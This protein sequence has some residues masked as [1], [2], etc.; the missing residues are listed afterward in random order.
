MIIA[1]LLA[2]LANRPAAAI[3]EFYRLVSRGEKVEKLAGSFGFT[4]GPVWIPEKGEL[5][6]SDIPNDRIVR[7]APLRTGPELATFRLP[8]GNSNGLVLD[9][10]GRLIACEHGNRRVSRTG[11]DG[12]VA[13][14]ADRFEGRRLNSPNDA[15]VRGDGSVYFTD[16]PYG[17]RGADRELSFQGVFR[18]APDGKLSLLVRDFVKPNG[19]A[20]SP[21]ER[22]LY[23]ADTEA[24]HIRAFEVAKNGS[25]R[26]GRVFAPIAW[27]DGMK[28]DQE[29]NVYCTGEGGVWIF[30]SN[31]RKYGVIEIPEAPANCAFGGA[32]GK[33]LFVTARTGLYRIRVNVAGVGATAVPP[34]A[35]PGATK[36][37]ASPAS[38]AP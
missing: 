9:R 2:V 30:D 1:L 27:P 13:I 37:C 3:D 11:K 4:E 32:N 21:D 6:F 14:L 34:T 35:A 23:V 25:V 29:G 17:V 36:G 5:L 28:V 33:V 22:T 24:G 20:F 26:K 10:E 15:A 7:W 38:L 18:I 16:P 8:S 19:L 31:G 12:A